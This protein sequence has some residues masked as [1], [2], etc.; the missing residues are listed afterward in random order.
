MVTVLLLAIL[1]T[2]ALGFALPVLALFFEVAWAW[3]ANLFDRLE[4]A[5]A[6]FC[7]KHGWY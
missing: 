4:T 1:A 2:L 5:A 3:Y 7:A 6:R